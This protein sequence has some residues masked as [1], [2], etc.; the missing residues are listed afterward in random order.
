MKYKF[1]TT[2]AT[3]TGAINRPV[4]NRTSSY[5]PTTAPERRKTFEQRFNRVLH[6]HV[7][8]ETRRRSS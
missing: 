3:I 8:D 1:P 5:E 4:N 2:A 7:A 6:L